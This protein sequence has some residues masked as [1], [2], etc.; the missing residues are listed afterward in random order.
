MSCDDCW[1]MAA[2]PR[3][4]ISMSARFLFPYAAALVFASCSAKVNERPILAGEASGT[5]SEDAGDGASQGDVLDSPTT[6]NPDASNNLSLSDATASMPTDAPT[7]SLLDGVWTGYIE[8]Y[9]FPSGTN[10]VTM[11]LSL[12]GSFETF[13]G[14]LTNIVTGTMVFG[15]GKA[16]PPATDPNVDYPPGYGL[17]PSG[18][19][20]TPPSVPPPFAGEGFVYTIEMGT[21]DGVSLRT[22][23]S[24]V[25][26]WKTWCA[27]QTSYLVQVSPATY[28]C[29]PGSDG[30]GSPAGVGG[31]WTC[32]VTNPMTQA[33]VP[34][35]CG[36][37]FVLCNGPPPFRPCR[38]DA[39]GCTVSW[40]A[41]DA[42]FD[43]A[44]SGSKADGTTA[45]QFGDHNVHFTHQ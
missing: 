16:P 34:V 13:G 20:R 12:S 23:V 28:G 32:S 9:M 35:D 39:N 26:L 44:V 21:F 30:Y 17:T 11:T 19:P 31:S 43:M 40:L 29:L 2:G 6:S 18:G 33:K 1:A 27:L 10:V 45:G 41:S 5:S 14:S 4:L 37:C 22:G 38:C 36:K 3:H 15:S 42:T 25:E 24:T 7:A 8:N